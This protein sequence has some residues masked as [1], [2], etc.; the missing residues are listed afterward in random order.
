MKLIYVLSLSHSGSTLLDCILGTH[1]DFQSSGEMRYINWQ[2]E[3]TKNK[4]ASVKAQDICTCENDFKICEFWSEVFRRINGKIGIDMAAHPTDF[5]TA[6]FKQ[7]A[8]QDRGGF[9]RSFID[10]AKQYLVLKWLEGGRSFKKIIWLEPK[11]KQWLANNWLLYETMS[12]VSEKKVVVD[13]SKNFTIALL[14][15][16]YCPNGVTFL[17]IHRSVEGLASSAKRWVA[18]AGKTYSLENIINIKKKFEKRVSKYKQNISKLSY[19][20]FEYEKFVAQPTTF[21]DNV[22]QHV[23]ANKYY[24]KQPNENFYIDPSQ[25][26]LV[27]GNPMR[28]RGRQLVKYDERW[29]QELTTKEIATINDLYYS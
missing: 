7:F 22:V 25:L 5:D 2:L 16:Q 13:S 20:D 14:L 15:Q 8:Y 9:N 4:R 21:L 19:L 18:K 11:I 28:Y 24:I 6:Y 27:A 10:K 3:R 12:D 23:G 17:F 26:H 29:K 1:P